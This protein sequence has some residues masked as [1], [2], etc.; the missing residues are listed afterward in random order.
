[1]KDRRIRRLVPVLLLLSLLTACVSTPKPLLPSRHVDGYTDITV[2]RL[3]EMLKEKDFTLV[4]VHIPYDGEIPET[5]EF[6]AFD[7]IADHLDRLPAKEARIVL[8]CRR[9]PMSTQAAQVLASLGYT[10]I[11]ELDGGMR[12]WAASGREVVSRQTFA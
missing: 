7:E 9:G 11:L 2:E 8:Y 5:D 10:S 12:A 3:A 4:N 1:M 6:I